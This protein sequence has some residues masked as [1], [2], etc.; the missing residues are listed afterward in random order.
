MPF[1][2]IF[3]LVIIIPICTSTHIFVSM[4]IIWLEIQFDCSIKSSKSTAS[5]HFIHISNTSFH[6]HSL[7]FLFDFYYRRQLFVLWF[8]LHCIVY[9]RMGFRFHIWAATR[10][11]SITIHTHIYTHIH[12]SVNVCTLYTM[13]CF[14]SVLTLVWLVFGLFLQCHFL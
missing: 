8:L 3:N 12:A 10:N 6:A 14:V 4:C 11:V 2:Q 7:L 5:R 13:L 9:L 1:P